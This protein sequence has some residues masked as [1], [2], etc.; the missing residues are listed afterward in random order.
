MT[1]VYSNYRHLD[2]ICEEEDIDKMADL[3]DVIFLALPHGV[4]SKKINESILNRTK[5]IVS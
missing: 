5:I 3:C 2:Y 1:K 4:A